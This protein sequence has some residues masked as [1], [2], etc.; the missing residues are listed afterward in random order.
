MEVP[1]EVIKYVDREVI[2]E[3]EKEVIK[4]VP[5]EVIK[6]VIREVPAMVSAEPTETVRERKTIREVTTKEMVIETLVTEPSASP[7]PDGQVIAA[8]PHDTTAETRAAAA[9]AAE[10]RAAE[11]EARALKMSVDT[12][13]NELAAA[14]AELA[15]A[16]KQVSTHKEAREALER[17]ASASLTTMCT[18]MKALEEAAVAQ[19]LMH[20]EEKSLLERV[21][22]TRLAIVCADMKAV[23]E[24]AADR[25][26]QL[27]AQREELDEFSLPSGG[28]GSEA[29]KFC[30]AKASQTAP[31][32]ATEAEMAEWAAEEELELPSGW[33]FEAKFC[34]TIHSDRAGG[35]DGGRE[36]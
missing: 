28:W 11:A 30:V 15:N 32:T 16:L 14:E 33:S 17:M 25:A 23:E 29:P 27:A 31:S 26:A 5:I 36:C 3:V 18:D 34:R 8:E 19:Q 24:E 9:A 13:R 6:E 22:N 7:P 1:V 12:I 10:R 4:E 21:A 35:G 20:T 2:K